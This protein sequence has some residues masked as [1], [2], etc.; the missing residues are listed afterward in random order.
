MSIVL[1]VIH[2][3]SSILMSDT[4][5]VHEDATGFHVVS[6]S[7]EKIF[8]LSD[9]VAV[10][11]TGDYPFALALLRVIVAVNTATKKFSDVVAR[12]LYK[13]ALELSPHFS[14]VQFVVTGLT[15]FGEIAS[16]TV[17][18]TKE[19]EFKE[20][21][22]NESRNVACISLYNKDLGNTLV[23]R[24]SAL[25]GA[26]SRAGETITSM[27]I[28]RCMAGYIKFVATQDRTVNDKIQI[29]QILP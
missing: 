22:L 9:T 4:R 1:N 5:R 8:S 2:P 3:G 7:T 23:D 16:Y 15:S 25:I 19:Y 10:G 6:E 20:Y 11:F 17:Q 14:D 13:K 26:K 18:G 24:V 12:L 28:A 29:I 21:L 27:D